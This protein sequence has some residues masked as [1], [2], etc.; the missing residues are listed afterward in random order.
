MSGKVVGNSLKWDLGTNERQWAIAME[1]VA[2]KEG[3]KKALPE[4]NDNAK[5][6]A[7]G[8]KR[9]ASKETLLMMRLIAERP[10]TTRELAKITGIT[11][12]QVSWRLMSMTPNEF[13]SLA[14]Y[15][16]GTSNQ[17]PCAIFKA[18]P[19]MAEWLKTYEGVR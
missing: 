17:R 7:R 10:Y 2:K 11:T 9:N 4:T 5:H 18:G 8:H 3:R 6:K 16:P 19:R 12:D 13:L 15:D 14:G 1:W